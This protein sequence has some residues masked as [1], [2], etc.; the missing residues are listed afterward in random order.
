[1]P[2]SKEIIEI[3]LLGLGTVG[4]GVVELLERNRS[5]IESRIGAPIRIT[6]ALVRDLTKPRLAMPEGL[7]ITDDPA[8]IL[9]DP[10]IKM[11]V[12]LMG[13]FE[14]SRTYI[15]QAIKAKKHVVTANKAVLAKHWEE[16]FQAAYENQVEVYLEASVG[17]G[18][19]CIQAI[20]DGLAAN[21]IS[22]LMAIVNGTTNYIL[23]R[24]AQDDKTFKESLAEAQKKG[25]AEADP[26][27]D[28][29]GYDA[30]HKLAILASIAF[31]QRVRIED[32][33]VQGIR[34]IS[35]RDIEDAR[36]ELGCAIKLLAI[37][38]AHGDG[39][40]ELRVAP[41]LIPLDH[42]LAWV[43]D[44]YNA[45]HV[46][47][48]AVGSVMFYG[49]GAGQMPTASAVISDIIYIARNIAAGVAGKV[50]AVAY[51]VNRVGSR[52]ILGSSE[53]K[54]RYFLRF[55]AVDQPGVLASIS[56][57][58]SDFNIS[59]SSVAQKERKKGDKV[60]VLISTY[61]ANEKDMLD[62][63]AAIERLPVIKDKTLLMRL[64]TPEEA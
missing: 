41:T 42:P 34:E 38:K 52:R 40:L 19:P 62:A 33:Q 48:D 23:T 51:D 12:E 37:A 47:G 60:P 44:V 15:L 18:I 16:I 36:E 28:I 4:S 32:I 14:P 63:I 59:I 53:I 8:R 31:D 3:G 55:V 13:G 22:S 49:R 24:M 43:D 2:K 45:V 56:G 6:R 50:P 30:C 35:K 1:M 21:R 17:G 7:E 26:T 20:N 25:Y 27:F 11:V 39:A 58:L 46:T 54:S 57:I 10:K 61:L 9:N 64:E 5:L 29:D